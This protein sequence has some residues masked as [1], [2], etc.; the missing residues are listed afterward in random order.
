HLIWKIEN[1]GVVGR[2]GI[3]VSPTLRPAPR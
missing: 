2:I 3:T 1:R